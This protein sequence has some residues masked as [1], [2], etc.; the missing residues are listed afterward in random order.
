MHAGG[1]NR[2]NAI[3]ALKTGHVDLV[4][5]GRHYLSNP[6]LPRRWREGA[7]LNKYHRP[8]FYSQGN[9]GYLDYPFLDGVPESAK[10]LLG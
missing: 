5:L 2:E 7:S 3:E 8:T 4:C 1:Y 10:K 9:E 6:D